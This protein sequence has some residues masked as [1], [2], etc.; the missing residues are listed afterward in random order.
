MKLQAF[1]MFKVSPETYN[2]LN[3]DNLIASA[4]Y[5]VRTS[6]VSKLLKLTVNDIQH[7]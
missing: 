4:R 1:E 3:S 5:E 2:I 6:L 7:S